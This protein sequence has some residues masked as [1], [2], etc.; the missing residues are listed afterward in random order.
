MLVHILV[1]FFFG[2]VTS[3]VHNPETV[4]WQREGGVACNKCHPA[5][6]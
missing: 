2:F 3:S 6:S 1:L 5:W 4:N